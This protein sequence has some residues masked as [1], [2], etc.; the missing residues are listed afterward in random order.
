MPGLCQL[1]KDMCQCS[2]ISTRDVWN[3]NYLS[4][5]RGQLLLMITSQM[6]NLRCLTFDCCDMAC[7]ICFQSI[8]STQDFGYL[9][10]LV[11]SLCAMPPS[12]TDLEL[13]PVILNLS[14]IQGVLLLI[15]LLL[16]LAVCSIRFSE[17]NFVF[18]YLC[19]QTLSFFI[20]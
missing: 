13:H 10:H 11:A 3:L 9:S 7:Q 1:K 5:L 6:S 19:F 8:A 16:F 18:G 17:R 20:S 14:V 2:P 15:H 4:I 12:T